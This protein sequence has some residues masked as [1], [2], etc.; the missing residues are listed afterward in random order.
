MPHKLCAVGANPVLYDPSAHLLLLVLIWAP[1]AAKKSS[2]STGR[3]WF[4][5]LTVRPANIFDSC[6]YSRN[7]NTA[8]LLHNCLPQTSERLFLMPGGANGNSPFTLS[9]HLKITGS[10]GIIKSSRSIKEYCINISHQP[11]LKLVSVALSWS[12]K[13]SLKNIDRK[14]KKPTIFGRD[15][16]LNIYSFQVPA[17]KLFLWSLCNSSQKSS[18]AERNSTKSLLHPTF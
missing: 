4:P 7:Q 16:F 9:Y 6:P 15:F 2:V 14:K 1:G 5:T 10:H 11:G 12:L 3:F 8:V 13:D 17:L 18:M